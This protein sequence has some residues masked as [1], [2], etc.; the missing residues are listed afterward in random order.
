MLGWVAKNCFGSR[1]G[2]VEKTAVGF[3]ESVEHQEMILNSCSLTSL[4][5]TKVILLKSYYI[6]KIFYLNSIQLFLK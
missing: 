5:L 6:F 2:A 1:T 4:S 3:S